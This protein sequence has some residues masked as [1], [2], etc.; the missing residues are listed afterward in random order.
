V[1]EDRLKAIHP[2]LADLLAS[3]GEEHLR[4]VAAMLARIYGSTGKFTRFLQPSLPVRLRS[5]RRTPTSRST[6]PS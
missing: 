6:G 4:Q 3:K 5:V 1:L 2:D